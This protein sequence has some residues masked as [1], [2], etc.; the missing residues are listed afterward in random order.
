[1][2]LVRRPSESAGSEGNLAELPIWVLHSKEARPKLN[3]DYSKTIDLGTVLNEDGRALERTITI[4]AAP[5]YGFPTMF[6]YRVLL[7]I[8]QEGREPERERRRQ[9]SAWLDARFTAMLASCAKGKRNDPLRCSTAAVAIASHS[10]PV[11][12]G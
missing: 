10:R 12:I 7:A 4:T 6:A 1:M 9:G 11:T 3:S 2:V 5:K 8:L